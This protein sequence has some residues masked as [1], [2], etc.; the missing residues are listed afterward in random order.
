[1][2]NHLDSD[3]VRLV[4]LK[5]AAFDV[6]LSPDVLKDDFVDL[7]RPLLRSYENRTSSLKSQLSPVDTR[8]Q[9]FLDAYLAGASIPGGAFPGCPIARW[10][11]IV[12]EWRGCCRC[13]PAA[14]HSV[15]RI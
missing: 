7:A 8:I 14:R 4:N 11:W 6:A 1:M 15:R 10:F 12:R 9:E 2:P 5:L 13:P 3:L